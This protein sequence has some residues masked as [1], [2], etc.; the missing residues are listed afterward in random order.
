[1]KAQTMKAVI[2][3]GYGAP[4]SLEIQEV[5]KPTPKEKQVLVKVIA[6]SVT[7]ADAMMRQG[8]PFFARFFL[9]FKKPKNPIPG[10]GFAGVVEATGTEVTQF[11]IGDEVFG[12]TAVDFS[13][14]AEYICVSEEGVILMKPPSISF[15]EAAPLCDGALTSFN[16]LKEIGQ[17][18]EG[19]RVLINGASGSLGTAAVQLAKYYGAHVTA[20]CSGKNEELV[21]SLGADDVIDYKKTDFTKTNERY[22]LIYDS[23]G[24]SSFSKCRNILTKEGQYLSPVLSLGVLFQMLWTSIFGTKKVRFAATGLL[25]KAKL[26]TFLIEVVDIIKKEQLRSHIDRRFALNQVVEAHH[27]VD[28]GRKRGNIVLLP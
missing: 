20:V 5:V 12:E 17:I 19:Q 27:F 4:E 21:R 15:E 8:T 7:A 1:M 10:T 18:K 22:D 14:H 13:A 26:R 28:T 6:T 23:I 9:G 11:K 3:T 2:C 16:F 25:P 24:K